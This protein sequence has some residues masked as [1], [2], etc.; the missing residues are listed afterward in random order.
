M[1]LVCW[2]QPSL[3]G[4]RPVLA[5]L[6][7]RGSWGDGEEQGHESPPGD[8]RQR[9]VASGSGLR[10]LPRP[11]PWYLQ[12]AVVAL[13]DLVEGNVQERDLVVAQDFVAVE[14]L[15]RGGRVSDTE[16]ES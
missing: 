8:R 6:K 15:G 14:D 5:E 9:G 12:A 4:P 2:R 16:H 11:Q 10:E 3:S 1:G 7:K 13:R